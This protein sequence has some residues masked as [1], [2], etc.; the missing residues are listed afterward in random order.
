MNDPSDQ[1]INLK[2]FCIP[3]ELYRTR[4]GDRVM[5]DVTCDEVRLLN[6]TSFGVAFVWLLAHL[7]FR[8]CAGVFFA[9]FSGNLVFHLLTLAL[10]SATRTVF[11]FFRR[12]LDCFFPRTCLDVCIGCSNQYWFARGRTMDRDNHI[13]VSYP[14]SLLTRSVKLIPGLAIVCSYGCRL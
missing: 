11:S 10:N 5:D 14:W 8:A 6:T 3:D 2:S 9:W 1:P 7:A 4:D 13:A 12:K